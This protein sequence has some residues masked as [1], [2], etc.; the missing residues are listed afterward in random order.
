MSVHGNEQATEGPG[1]Y[2]KVISIVCYFPSPSGS[3]IFICPLFSIPDRKT[4]IIANPNLSPVDR[5]PKEREYQM[6]EPFRQKTIKH[7]GDWE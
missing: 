6:N 4:H 5:Y 2:F 1:I 7:L 3:E